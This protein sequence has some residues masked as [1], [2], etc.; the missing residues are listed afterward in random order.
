MF[1][2]EF[3]YHLVINW[4]I[5]FI[6]MVDS[7]L[8]FELIT[9]NIVVKIETCPLSALK[10]VDVTKSRGDICRKQKFESQLQ[11][12]TSNLV[13]NPKFKY[14]TKLNIKEQIKWCHMSLNRQI[15][16]CHVSLGPTKSR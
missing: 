14:V 16:N 3:Q 15:K 7:S 1:E 10:I 9:S 13:T 6:N 8:L 11:I 12:A 4:H 5:G 2:V